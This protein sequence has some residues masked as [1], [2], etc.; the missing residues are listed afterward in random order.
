M[1]PSAPRCILIT[2]PG[3]SATRLLV[4]ML[5][6]HPQVAVPLEGLNGV[7]EFEPLHQYFRSTL[8]RTSLAA[9]TYPIERDDLAVLLDAYRD[10]C[11]AD[12]PWYVL[13]APFF[14]LICLPQCL[15]VLG[16]DTVLLFTKRPVEKIIRSFVDRGED[17]GPADDL[18][19]TLLRK[20]KRLDVAGRR[21]WLASLDPMNYLRR[22]VQRCEDLRRQWDTRHPEQAFVTVDMERL[23]GSPD[24]LA[25]VLA[26]IG[27]DPGPATAM[28]AVIDQARL[29]RH[30]GPLVRYLRRVRRRLVK[31]GGAWA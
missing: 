22:Y 29:M 27:L 15:D 16:R 8:D 2:G 11:G 6:R 17:T 1:T 5:A 18:H 7:Q 26:E 31:N 14:P 3:H 24:Y 12:R 25:D 28:A 20:A 13:K 19:A 9:E 4:Q 30:Q 23:A 10:R 21:A